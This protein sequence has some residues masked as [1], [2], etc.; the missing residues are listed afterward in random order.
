M[1]LPMLCLKDRITPSVDAVHL[2]SFAHIAKYKKT[3]PGQLAG[4]V[5]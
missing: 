1:I 5:E 4:S 3:L 2:Q